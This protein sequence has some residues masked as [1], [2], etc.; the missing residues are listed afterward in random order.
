M[1]NQYGKIALVSGQ[2]VLIDV[3]GTGLSGIVIGNESGLTCSVTLQGANVKKTLYPGTVDKF[4]VPKGQSWTGNLQI[5]PTTDLNNVNSW[6]SSHIYI[7]TYGIN[8]EIPGDFPLVLNR[9]GNIGNVVTTAMGG[10][11]SLQNDGNAASTVFIEATQSGGP[12]SNYSGTVDGSLQIN[13]WDGVTKKNIFQTIANPGAGNP[14]IKLLTVGLIAEVIG[15]LLFDNANALQ[16]KDSGGV[17]RTVFQVDGSNNVQTFGITGQNIIQWLTAAGV[18]AA[19]INLANGSL[20]LSTAKTTTNGGTAGTAEMWMPFQGP[21]FKVVLITEKGFRTAAGNQD[22]SFPVPFVNGCLYI[23]TDIVT[24]SFLKAGVV[25][26]NNMV[27]AFGTAVFQATV[28]SY[29][30]GNMAPTVAVD[31]IRHNG[32]AGSNHTGWILMVGN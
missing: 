13:Q 22:V 28:T 10:S 15:T 5:N 3:G 21:A 25:Q 19:A 31:A 2:Q 20:D 14:S 24:W 32:G 8:E 11:T 7:D 29:T 12:A 30:F 26:N 23:C 16:Y 4:L 27:T 1:S 17:A 9:A 18:L 6:P